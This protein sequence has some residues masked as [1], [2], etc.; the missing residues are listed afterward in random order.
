MSYPFLEVFCVFQ[1]QISGK[2][3]S[4]ARECGGLYYFEKDV[5]LNIQAQTMS[6]MSLSREQKIML[7][8]RRLGH[9]S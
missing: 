4:N 9:P 3:I 7:W 2:K 8:H 5:E 1:D 6:C